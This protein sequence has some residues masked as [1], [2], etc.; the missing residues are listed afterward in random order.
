MIWGASSRLAKYWL[1][2]AEA[3]TSMPASL[4]GLPC[5]AVRTGA[6]SAVDAMSTSAACNRTARLAASSA[7]QSR[8]ALA[9]ASKAASSCWRVHSGAWAKT[10]PV[11]GFRTPNVPSVGAAS[12]AMV[13]TNS[14]MVLLDCALWEGFPLPG[15]TSVLLILPSGRP[16][17]NRNG[18]A[19]R[20][21]RQRCVVWAAGLGRGP[22][23][24]YSPMPS[25]RGP[26]PV[27]TP[28]FSRK[29][30]SVWSSAALV[31]VPSLSTRC[32]VSTE[33]ADLGCP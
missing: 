17:L 13:M 29:K 4:S 21:R 25:G 10:S 30:P 1:Q 16:R 5:S 14:D 2:I 18:P 28:S 26:G 31:G 15:R 11:A 6:S 3:K 12:P 7:F 24:A 20:P 8:A 9:A 27:P 32:S 22:R 23:R 19:G 33:C